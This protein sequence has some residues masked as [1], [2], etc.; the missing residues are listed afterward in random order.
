MTA[1]TR[2]GKWNASLI[3]LVLIW[4]AGTP[5]PTIRAQGPEHLEIWDS[6]YLHDILQVNPI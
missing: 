4:S 3:L 1:S 2:P 6:E 5:N